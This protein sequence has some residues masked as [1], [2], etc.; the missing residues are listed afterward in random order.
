M[1]VYILQLKVLLMEATSRQVSDVTTTLLVR[2]G[3]QFATNL[4]LNFE[5]FYVVKSFLN[6]QTHNLLPLMTLKY[7]HMTQIISRAK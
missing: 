6:V 2:A 4:A 5:G 3:E 1:P 7:I